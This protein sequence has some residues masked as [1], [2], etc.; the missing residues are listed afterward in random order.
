MLKIPTE[1]ERDISLAKFITISRYVSPVS[2]GLCQRV[3]VDE[4]G[5]NKTQME[6]HDRSENGR[7]AWNAVCDATM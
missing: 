5:M 7:S 4:L 1:Y 3:L 6:K 2:D